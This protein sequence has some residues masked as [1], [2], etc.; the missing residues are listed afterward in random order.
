MHPL[1]CPDKREEDAEQQAN[2]CLSSGKAP[3]RQKEEGLVVV[4]AEMTMVLQ[5]MSLFACVQY[6]DCLPMNRCSL[7]H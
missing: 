7:A 6:L 1:G 2:R 5:D 3:D 4:S